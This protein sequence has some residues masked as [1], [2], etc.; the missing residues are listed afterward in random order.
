MKKGEKKENWIPRE[1]V[2]CLDNVEKKIDWVWG[3]N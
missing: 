1:S 2:L 3:W